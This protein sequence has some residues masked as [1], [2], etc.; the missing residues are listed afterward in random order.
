M[1]IDLKEVTNLLYVSNVNFYEMYMDTEQDDITIEV[2]SVESVD[3]DDLIC[4]LEDIFED[5]EVVGNTIYC[6]YYNEMEY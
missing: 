4:G 2:E 5:V 3:M 1:R 6:S